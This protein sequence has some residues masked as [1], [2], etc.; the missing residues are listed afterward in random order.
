[1]ELVSSLQY[2]LS[3]KLSQIT[4]HQEEV[5][6]V[7]FYLISEYYMGFSTFSLPSY[8]VL[9]KLI[10]G[11][12]RVQCHKQAQYGVSNFFSSSSSRTKRR[13]LKMKVAEGACT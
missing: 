5:Q 10:L 7:D 6:R 4:G 11:K 9:A 12:M 13:M 2:M 3:V 8:K 1:M